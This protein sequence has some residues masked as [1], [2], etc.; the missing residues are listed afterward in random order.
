M[1]YQT[2]QC[3]EERKARETRPTPAPAAEPRYTPQFH[4]IDELRT[5]HGAERD[6]KDR[7][8]LWGGG[9]VAGLLVF[10]VLW[11]IMLSLE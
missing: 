5:R 4:T 6:L 3:T 7:L 1:T 9:I 11:L 2:E 10:G 8:Y